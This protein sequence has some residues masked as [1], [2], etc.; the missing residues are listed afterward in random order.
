MLL[1]SFSSSNKD[2][3]TTSGVLLNANGA[4]EASGEQQLKVRFEGGGTRGGETDW[5]L[6][7]QHKQS[8]DLEDDAEVDNVMKV[9]K[10]E[11]AQEAARL[12]H[13]LKVLYGFA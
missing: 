1:R 4:T 10:I 9:F 12:L 5:R 3:A 2:G 7:P 8:T 6:F 11:D 13:S